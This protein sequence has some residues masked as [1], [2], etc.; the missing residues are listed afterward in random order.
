MILRP[1]L[2]TTSDQLQDAL[3]ALETE[4]LLNF[5]YLAI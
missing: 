2:K 3:P 4:K 5:S 1:I